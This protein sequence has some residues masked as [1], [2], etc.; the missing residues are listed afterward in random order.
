MRNKLIFVDHS[1]HKKTHSSDFFIEIL[2]SGGLDVKLI[3]DYSWNE[4]SRYDIGY[5]INSDIDTVLFWQVLPTTNELRKLRNKKIILV[6]MY[7]SAMAVSSSYWWK[8]KKYNLKIISFSSTLHRILLSYG[9]K[10]MYLK[11]FPNIDCE[12]ME[13]KENC[14]REGFSVFFWQ[15]ITDLNW[16]HVKILLGNTDVK[17]VYLHKVIDPGN[18]LILPNLEDIKKYNIT[19]TEWFPDRKSYFDILKE[20]D[21]YFAPRLCEGIGFSFLEA[22]GYGCV[23]V[24]PN[25]PTMNEYI[26]KNNGYLYDYLNIK[27]LKFSKFYTIRSNSVNMFK[28]GL[29]KWMKQ[30][31]KI[32]PFILEDYKK[33]K[34]VSFYNF[35]SIARASCCN[36]RGVIRYYLNKYGL[37][38]KIG[39]FFR[40]VL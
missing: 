37:L 18:K 32:I 38:S 27:P 16:Q 3:Y 14:R 9:L 35:Y 11:Y 4:G 6:P 19:F 23:V 20:C 33:A 39:R 8:L 29:E 34:M 7:D 17:K 31:D 15:R 26:K 5:I 13:N 21:I 2:K 36:I 12:Y 22:M 30:K 40:G 25:Y 1:Y 28:K 24:A 10:T